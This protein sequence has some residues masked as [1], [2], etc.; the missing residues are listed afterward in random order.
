MRF[1]TCVMDTKRTMQSIMPFYVFMC[2]VCTCTS[3]IT[4][5]HILVFIKV[6]MTLFWQSFPEVSSTPTRAH[7][8]TTMVIG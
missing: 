2:H 7:E 1:I 8:E 3:N 4:I 5:E 6:S